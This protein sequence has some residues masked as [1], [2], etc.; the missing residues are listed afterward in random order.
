MRMKKLKLAIV[1]A[2]KTQR[3]V[4]F[5]TNLLTEN[6]LSEIICGWIMPRDDEKLALSRVLKQP[7]DTL[8][9]PE[10]E[11]PAVFQEASVDIRSGRRDAV[12]K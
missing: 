1:S 10:E 7:I 5:E 2:D 4:A 6:R 9:E 11:H 12:T 3:Q 8:F